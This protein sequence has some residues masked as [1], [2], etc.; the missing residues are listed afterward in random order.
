MLRATV[1]VAGLFAFSAIAGG[2]GAGA[3]SKNVFHRAEKAPPGLDGRLAAVARAGSQALGVAHGAG[4]DVAGRR[5]RVVV[6]ATSLAT[7][8]SSVAAAGGSTEATYANL[9]ESFV[10]PAAL[11]KL[12][13]APGVEAVRAP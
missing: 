5:V 3:S 12:A 2:A 13:A 6:D 7:A 11:T 4:L 10:P 1:A 9:I 8:R